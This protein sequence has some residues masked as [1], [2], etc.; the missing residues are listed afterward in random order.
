MQ[1]IVNQEGEPVKRYSPKF[2]TIGL[3][4]DIEKLIKDGPAALS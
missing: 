1:F 3:A 4:D 2:E